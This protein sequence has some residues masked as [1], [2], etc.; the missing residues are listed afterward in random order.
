MKRLNCVAG[1][2]DKALFKARGIA[3]GSEFR[4]KGVNVALGPVMGPLG[5]QQAAGR[6]WEGFGSDPYLQGIA[7]AETIKGIQ[8][9]GVVATAKH[10]IANEQEHFRQGVNALS[11][12]VDDRTL[13][14]VYLWPFQNSVK[15]GVGAVMCAY[16]KINN[17][18]ACQ[19][20]WLQ[21]GILK[22]EL[23]FQGFIMR[24]VLFPDVGCHFGFG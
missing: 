14:E 15:A 2:W 16:N 9:A 5:R 24:S 13:H 1:T 10:F 18:A 11:S 12:N 17:S 8:S 23:G 6:N 20:S 7:A 3:M 19:N 21:N 4:G 22:D